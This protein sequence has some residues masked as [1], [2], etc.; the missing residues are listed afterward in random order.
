MGARLAQRPS[1]GYGF[2]DGDRPCPLRRGGAQQCDLVRCDG[3]AHGAAGAFEGSA[4]INR[5]PA[6]RL[7]PNLVTLDGPHECAAHMDG[8]RQ[9]MAQPPAPAWAVKDSFAALDLAESGFQLLFE[10]AWIHRPTLGFDAIAADVE[11]LRVTSDAML[12]AWEKAWR[13]DAVAPRHRLFRTAL[14]AEPDHAIIAVT[15]D[16][17]IVAG[18][19]ASRSDGLVGISNLFVRAADDHGLRAAC[20]SAAMRLAPGSALVGYE[21]GQDLRAMTALGFSEIGALRVWQA[22]D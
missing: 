18:C 4:W 11:M 12:A 13:A 3:T 16:Q 21:S 7:Y 19:I 14:L 22:A 9:L 8:T 6:P 1:V 15:R 2:A 20:L 10:A 5:R 17:A